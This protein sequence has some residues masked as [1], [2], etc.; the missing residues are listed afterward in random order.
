MSNDNDKP[1]PILLLLAALVLVTIWCMSV[2]YFFDARLQYRSAPFPSVD[3]RMTD[4]F[5]I[6]DTFSPCGPAVK[7]SEPGLNV[8]YNYSVDGRRYFGYRKRF[9]ERRSCKL[10]M[11]ALLTAQANQFRTQITDEG[12]A[13]SLAR[14]AIRPIANQK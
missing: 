2:G 1:N 10:S 11:D 5:W 7:Q 12:L 9:A 4:Y 14:V 3:G 13:L 8:E 6:E